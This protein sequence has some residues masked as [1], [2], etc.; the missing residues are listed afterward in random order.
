MTNPTILNID[1]GV[2]E[3]GDNKF[4]QETLL[5]G[6]VVVKGD[7]LGF[8]TTSGKVRIT[9]SAAVDGSENARVVAFH[10]VDASGGDKNITVIIKGN[11]DDSLLLFD[12]ADTLATVVAGQPDTYEMMLRDYGILAVNYSRD[13]IQDNQ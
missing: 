9:K 3:T 13:Q 7:V 1:S 4:R 2:L 5:S 6:E 12:G 10:D 8:V 11:V